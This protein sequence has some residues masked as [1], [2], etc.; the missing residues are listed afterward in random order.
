LQIETSQ[1]TDL[2]FFSRDPD[3]E[4]VL[5]GGV[6]V[7]GRFAVLRQVDGQ[8]GGAC[9]IGGRLLSVGGF[10]LK[11]ESATSTGKIVAVDR[12]RGT[13]D[14]D[15]QTTDPRSLVGRMIRF[16]N[17]RRTSTY[18]ITAAEKADHGTRLTLN[19]TSLIGEGVV[20]GVDDFVIHNPVLTFYGSLQVNADGTRTRGHSLYVGATLENEAG[21]VALPVE[22]VTGGGYWGSPGDVYLDRERSPQATAAWL[23]ATLSDANGDGA[24][25]FF[26]YDYGVGEAYEI[27]N[28]AYSSG[29]IGTR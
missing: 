22:G 7:Q 25:G 8:P 10:S 15:L 20:G 21:A 27:H 9:L 17:D 2:L 26:L 19:T 6:R 12:D 1:A 5:P 24:A 14:I 13:V 3:R 28:W 18:T 4:M 11:L 23:K 16:Y 29:G